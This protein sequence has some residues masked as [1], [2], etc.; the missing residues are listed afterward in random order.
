MYRARIYIYTYTFINVN[1]LYIL[2]KFPF[3][4]LM[5]SELSYF[6]KN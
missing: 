3:S 4:Y 6:D 5:E 2:S 1:N